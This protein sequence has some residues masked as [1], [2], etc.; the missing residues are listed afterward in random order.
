LNQILNN[1]F[2]FAL[3]LQKTHL[4]GI[5]WQDSGYNDQRFEQHGGASKKI[6]TP[7]RKRPFSAITITE[8]R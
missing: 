4:A 8:L 5:G 3:I 2:A 6:L 1:A 7:R